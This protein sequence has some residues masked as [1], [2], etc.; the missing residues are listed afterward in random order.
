[1]EIKKLKVKEVNSFWKWFSDNCGYFGQNFDNEELLDDLDNRINELGEFTWEIG[2]GTSSMN[3]LVI[4]PGGDIDL[5]P[6]TKEI[7]SYAPVVFDWEFYHAKPPKEWE[8]IFDFEKD[9]GNA[10]EINASQWKYVLLKYDDGMFEVILQTRDLHGFS[11]DDKI[12]ISEILLDGIL[13]EERRMLFICGVDVTEEFEDS[14]KLKS[15]NIKSL[16]NQMKSLI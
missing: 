2:P 14:Y 5:L 13:G 10:V 4:S 9:D 15:S 11:E 8:F 7:V 16:S 6:Y 3:Q 1:M 12:V